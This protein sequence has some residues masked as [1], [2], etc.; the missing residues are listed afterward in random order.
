MY[1]LELA[2]SKCGTLS[3]ICDVLVAFQHLYPRP[4]VATVI[5]SIANQ[6]SISF[7]TSLKLSGILSVNS[8]V[9]IFSVESR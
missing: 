7:A 1:A 8:G 2:V 5:D 6:V 3:T 9:G 4:T